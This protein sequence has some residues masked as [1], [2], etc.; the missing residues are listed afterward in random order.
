M[1]KIGA[2]ILSIVLLFC[3][4]VGC[5]SEASD[6]MAEM[7]ETVELQNPIIRLNGFDETEDLNAMQAYN[8]FGKVEIERDE[9]YIKNG[10]GSAKLTVEKDFFNGNLGSIAP[11]VHHAMYV[12]SRGLDCCNFEKTTAVELDFYNP[13]TTDQKIGLQ[14]IYSRTYNGS[15]VSEAAQW[16]T[17]KANEWTTLR[18]NVIRDNI[19]L[20]K[21]SSTRRDSA[22]DLVPLVAGM[23]ILFARPG[24]DENDLTFFV[25]DMRIYKTNVGYETVE[26]TALKADEICSFDQQWQVLGLGMNT[27]NNLYRC[28]TSWSK[29]FTSDGGASLRVDTAA[30]GGVNGGTY[31]QLRKASMFSTLDLMDYSQQDEFCFDMYSPTEK[32]FTGNIRIFLNSNI[33]YF[34]SELFAVTPGR[35]TQVRLSV[36][37][38]N[39][40]EYAKPENGHCFEYLTMIQIV[41]PYTGVSTTLYID[42]IRME[43]AS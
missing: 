1:R 16:Y 10:T 41:V 2:F 27:T 12:P 31:V 21:S 25:D 3:C 30:D 38:I 36:A 15:T 6:E 13:Q 18:W 14:L 40:S 5:Y 34:Y 37:E 4:A 26:K 32:G 7:T 33:G 22:T 42:N 43:R 28:S 39:A 24:A 11:Y 17:L 29:A 35:I 19:P 20:V 9:K 23:D 8:Y